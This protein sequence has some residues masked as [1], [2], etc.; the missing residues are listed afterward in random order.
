MSKVIATA[1]DPRT[2]EYTVVLRAVTGPAWRTAPLLRLKQFL[3]RA[4]RDWGLVAV[5][6]TPT[7]PSEFQRQLLKTKGT[8]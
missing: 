2:V 4:K 5:R 8:Q 6:C 7:D 3:K 1:G